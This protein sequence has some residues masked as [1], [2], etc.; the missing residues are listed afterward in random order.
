[1]SRSV[2]I[3][4]AWYEGIDEDMF[5]GR[6]MVTQYTNPEDELTYAGKQHAPQTLLHTHVLVSGLGLDLFIPIGV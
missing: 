2:V 5:G 1:M 3:E 6:I 4:G